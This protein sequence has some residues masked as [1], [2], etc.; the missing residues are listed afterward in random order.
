[1]KTAG[2]AL[3]RAGDGGGTQAQVLLQIASLARK[4]AGKA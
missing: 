3:E 4:L 2:R 1:M